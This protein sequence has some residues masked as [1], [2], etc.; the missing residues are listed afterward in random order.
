MLQES[1]EYVESIIADVKRLGVEFKGPITYTS[2]YFPE[3]LDLAVR[4]IRAGFL[5]ADDTPVEQM[6][7]VSI[8]VSTARSAAKCVLC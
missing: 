2:D 7:E 5:Y 6:R 3:M 8:R 4:L 1:M